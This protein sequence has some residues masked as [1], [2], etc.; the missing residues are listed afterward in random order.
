MPRTHA[1]GSGSLT[2]ANSMFGN[3]LKAACALFRPVDIQNTIWHMNSNPLPPD[4]FSPDFPWRLGGRAVWWVWVAFLLM[5]PLLGAGCS[6]PKY[7]FE[8]SVTNRTAQALSVGLVKNGGP[9]EAGWDSPEQIATNAPQLSER[10]W[11][12][13]VKPGQTVVIGPQEGHFREGIAA[14]LRV[15]GADLAVEDLIAF[16]RNDP[17]RLD[18]YIWPGRSGYVISRSEGRLRSETLDRTGTGAEPGR[19]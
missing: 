11:G 17:D 18:I 16:G 13:L 1:A 2:P 12:T 8:V 5:L 10:K 6:T 3:R 15:Y 9:L 7:T 14:V 19:P 4:T